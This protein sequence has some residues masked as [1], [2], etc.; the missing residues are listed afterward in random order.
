VGKEEALGLMREKDKRD[1]QE[2]SRCQIGHVRGKPPLSCAEPAKEDVDGLLLCEGHALEAKLEG[3][4][5]CWDEMLFHIDLWAREA[6]RRDR[7]DVVE[8]LEDERVEAIYARGRAYLDLDVLRRSETPWGGGSALGR[9]GL[10]RRG[11][12]PLPPTDAR[13][14][15][16][17]LRRLRRR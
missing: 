9:R 14:L 7:Q 11:S 6:R 3:Q 5:S 1:A 13:P 4:I 12:L 8:L 15:A 10:S 16:R 17:G 2:R